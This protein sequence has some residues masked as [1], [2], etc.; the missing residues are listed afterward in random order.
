MVY[1]RVKSP[2]TAD[3][4]NK[5]LESKDSLALT[6][7]NGRSR[8]SGIDLQCLPRAPPERRRNQRLGAARDKYLRLRL[9]FDHGQ[10]GN[11][12]FEI[13]SEL[14]F[15]GLRRWR[16]GVG[17]FVG[18]LRLE[19]FL[20]G[21]AMPPAVAMVPDRFSGA[22]S[23]VYLHRQR[24]SPSNRQIGSCNFFVCALEETASESLVRATTLA[25]WQ[26]LRSQSAIHRLEL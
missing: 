18:T 11:Q 23:L 2:A 25:S 4:A 7:S 9:D 1:P 24:P 26:Q 15:L 8:L 10:K 19:S 3:A 21:I 20:S 6:S 13:D 16:R 5:S 17:R 14:S 12:F 22:C